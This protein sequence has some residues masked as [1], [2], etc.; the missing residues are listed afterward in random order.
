MESACLCAPLLWLLHLLSPVSSLGGF[1]GQ[2]E[3]NEHPIMWCC[4][5]IMLLV[6]LLPPKKTLSPS[7][8]QRNNP[9][10]LRVLVS[11]RKALCG[12]GPVDLLGESQRFLGLKCLVLTCRNWGGSTRGKTWTHHCAGR[13]SPRAGGSP[14]P[15]CCK[16][17]AGNR[18]VVPSPRNLPWAVEETVV[19]MLSVRAL[20]ACSWCV[21]L[22]LSVRLRGSRLVVSVS[23]NQQS[24]GPGKLA[25]VFSRSPASSFVFHILRSQLHLWSLVSWH[26]RSVPWSYVVFWRR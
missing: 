16:C 10:P 8:P 12:A 25:S 19:V 22:M 9:P 4:I 13:L 14:V 18:R 26:G 23:H 5:E 17:H 15:P 7:S 11:L 21:F 6:F 20:G 2:A 24:A 3:A 1:V